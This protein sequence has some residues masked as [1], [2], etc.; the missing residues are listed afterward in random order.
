MY[1]GYQ[2]FINQLK[3][4]RDDRTTFDFVFKKGNDEN[5]YEHFSYS[6]KVLPKLIDHTAMIY[7]YYKTD[8]NKMIIFSG[9]RKEEKTSNDTCVL[10]AMSNNIEKNFGLD[11]EWIKILAYANVS[12]TVNSLFKSVVVDG[13]LLYWLWILL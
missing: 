4:I 7:G 11:N 2:K 5:N 9:E 1:N 8:T 3:L 12:L 6:F 10:Y 13:K